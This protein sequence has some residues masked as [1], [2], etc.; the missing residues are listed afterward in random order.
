MRKFL[1]QQ[2]QRI[3][4]LIAFALLC[5]AFLIQHPQFEQMAILALLLIT[6]IYAFAT[7]Q[8]SKATTKQAET[9]TVLASR[10]YVKEFIRLEVHPLLKRCK[11]IQKTLDL[12]YFGHNYETGWPQIYGLPTELGA[13]ETKVLKI[14]VFNGREVFSFPE[15]SLGLLQGR[16]IIFISLFWRHF[17]KVHSLLNCHWHSLSN[18]SFP[19]SHLPA[20]I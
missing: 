15:P 13:E 8:I 2:W 4:F 14:G 1:R 17:P 18:S 11:E 12:N 9:T 20:S 19:V 7:H 16:I 6:L 10:E 5:A 3:I